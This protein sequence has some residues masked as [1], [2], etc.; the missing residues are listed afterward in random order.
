MRAMSVAGLF[1][2]HRRWRRRVDASVDAELVAPDVRRVAVPLGGC[3]ACRAQVD[4]A[5]AVRQL[6][7]DAPVEPAPRSF[8]VTP[9]ML[10]AQGRAAERAGAAGPGMYAFM[11]ASQALAGVAVLAFAFLV[12]VDLSGSTAGDDDDDGGFAGAAIE[13]AGQM[14]A[15]G[16]DTGA[17][18]AAATDAAPEG[19][20][21]PKD[22]EQ[23]DADDGTETTLALRDTTPLADEGG[24][25]DGLRIAQLVAAGLAVLAIAGYVVARRTTREERG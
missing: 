19:P 20:P 6:L 2:P 17:A 22:R 13:N 16:D 11:R 23:P 10:Q 12:V 14:S 5:R 1:R 4:A 25:R 15:P 8:R 9:A 21:A 18:P 3:D 7:A 24:G